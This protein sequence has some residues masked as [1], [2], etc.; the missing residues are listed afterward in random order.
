MMSK[1]FVAG[2]VEIV[3][4]AL[5]TEERGMWRRKAA[6]KDNRPRE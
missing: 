5:A 1:S 6:T 2:F 3:E 4:I